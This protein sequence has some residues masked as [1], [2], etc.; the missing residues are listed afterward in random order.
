MEALAGRHADHS[1]RREA[2]RALA[3]EVTT[4][5][6]AA[7]ALE[8]ARRTTSVLFDGGDLRSLSAGEIEEGLRE[9]PRAAVRRDEL[10]PS[11]FDL[12][13]ALLRCGLAP[14]RG[15]ART[16][17]ESVSSGGRNRLALSARAA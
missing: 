5:V 10:D 9:A 17:I 8:S 7:A 2:H 14:S 16:A 1:E 13:A 6:H 15:Q 3:D 4:F 11:G 12:A